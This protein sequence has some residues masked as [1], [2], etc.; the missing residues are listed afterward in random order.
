MHLNSSV[1]EQR[2]ENPWVDSSNLSLDT[3]KNMKNNFWY[4]LAHIKNGQKAN[5]SY[6][7]HPKEKNCSL[8]LNILWEE[9][10][11]LGYKISQKNP[12]MFLIFLKYKHN[13]S[14]INHLTAIT[15]PSCKVY[16]S[17]KQLWKINNNL[18]LFLIST[19]KGILTLD[20]C[21][22]LNIGGELLFLIQ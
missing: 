18:G 14:V 19:N 1:V 22:K 5:K 16:C 3:F 20:V 10:Y 4:M 2:T 13:N 6:I 7:L 15:K 8:I 9:G 21:K 12:E 11:I 17:I